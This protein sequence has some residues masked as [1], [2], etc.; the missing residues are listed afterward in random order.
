MNMMALMVHEP[1][2]KKKPRGAAALVLR[3]PP[4][5]QPIVYL[6]CHGLGALLSLLPTKIWWDSMWAHTGVLAF[7]IGIGIWNGASF[8][9]KVFAKRYLAEL[10]AQGGAKKKE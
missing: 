6:S 7:C 3:M 2:K 8:Y 10:E 1:A 9:F 5:L 4:L